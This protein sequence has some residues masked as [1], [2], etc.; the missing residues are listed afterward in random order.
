MSRDDDA[1]RWD[2]DED[3][4]LESSAASDDGARPGASAP[5][6]HE[7]RPRGPLGWIA[8]ALA[9][10]ATAGWIVIVVANPVQQPSLLGLVMYQLGELLA[11]IAPLLWWWCVD[12]LAPLA[13]RA[14]WWI[15]GLAVTAPWPLVAG[16]LA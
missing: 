3:L 14:P 10:A 2:G 13:R 7:A 1:L 5:L 11:V 12:R 8:L 15:A 6:V 9:L 16:V 4:D